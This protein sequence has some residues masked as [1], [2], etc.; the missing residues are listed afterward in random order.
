LAETPRSPPKF[1]H[2]S[3]YGTNQPTIPLM[4]CIQR[5]WVFNS[6][7]QPFVVK[8]QEKSIP[9]SIA[10]HLWQEIVQG[11]VRRF[12][13]RIACVDGPL[14]R[15]GHVPT[16][17]K[18]RTTPSRFKVDPDKFMDIVET[19]KPSIAIALCDGDTSKGIKTLA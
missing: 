12:V 11:I 14:L 8:F 7:L 4:I 15:R 5:V 6:P 2:A 18:C 9:N 10:I 3:N 17:A 1:W 16:Y 13:R 19:A